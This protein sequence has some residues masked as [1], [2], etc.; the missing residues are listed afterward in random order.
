MSR[1]GI[2]FAIP[3]TESL[4]W[5]ANCWQKIQFLLQFSSTLKTVTV[6]RIEL[7]LAQILGKYWKTIWHDLQDWKSTCKIQVDR[8][9][10]YMRTNILGWKSL[11]QKRILNNKTWPRY[12]RVTTYRLIVTSSSMNENTSKW[13]QNMCPF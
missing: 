12:N 5:L 9:K 10:L 7:Q 3:L 1:K 4:P 11:L 13:I 6:T 2:Q 8:S